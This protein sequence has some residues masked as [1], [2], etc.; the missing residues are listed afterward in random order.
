MLGI[1]LAD[2]LA[3][4]DP[5]PGARLAARGLLDGDALSRGVAR[6]TLDGRLVADH[7]ARELLAA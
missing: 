4:A 1:R 6:L 3:L 5:A 2:G 7:V